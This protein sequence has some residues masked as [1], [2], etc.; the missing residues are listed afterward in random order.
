[1]AASGD[2]RHMKLRDSD[3]FD[4]RTAI[5]GGIAAVGS[6]LTAGPLSAA[7]AR[8]SMT[9]LGGNVQLVQ[10]TGTNTVVYKA[11]ADGPMLIVDPGSTATA[12]ALYRLAVSRKA[13]SLVVINT[14]W[15]PEQTAANDFFGKSGARIIAHEN[16]RLWMTT[17]IACR[18]KN[19]TFQPRAKIAQPVETFYEKHA[20]AVGNA[21]IECGY[22]LQAHTDGDVYVHFRDA[23]VLVV[24]DVAAGGAYP[25][26]D[27]CTNG[28]ISEMVAAQNT[29]LAIANADTRI[30]AGVGPVMTRAQLQEQRDMLVV[31]RDRL[32]D[33]VKKGLSPD[34]LVAAKPTQDFDARYG[35]PELMIRNAARG[36]ADNAR[37]VPGVV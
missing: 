5:A 24:G 10:G 7:A 32:F 20:V 15:H 27:Y 33:L 37:L 23:N 12:Q 31:V 13:A 11:S 6:L 26:T 25:I 19:Q 30:V 1:M 14:H 36:M 9:S 17:P 22:M 16:T 4:R 29:L 3:L 2:N 35:N 34:E 28:W 18:W 8:L 21:R